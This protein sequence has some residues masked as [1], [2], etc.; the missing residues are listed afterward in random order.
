[1]W[2]DE[3]YGFI[4]MNGLYLYSTLVEN[5]RSLHK[6]GYGF[7]NSAS[8]VIKGEVEPLFE[9]NLGKNTSRVNPDPVLSHVRLASATRGVK[10]VSVVN[11][12]PFEYSHI[13]LA[14]N[15]S[16]TPRSYKIWDDP[17]YKD[18]IDSDAFGTMVNG[19]IEKEGCSVLQALSTAYESW[20]G[21]FAF[22]IY[23]KDDKKFYVCRGET[24]KL[25]ITKVLESPG[26]TIGVVINTDKDAINRSINVFANQLQVL[27]GKTVFWN[28][29]VEL[30]EN[31]VYEFSDDDL[32][33]I[34]EVK[35]TK[36]VAPVAH[37]PAF[38]DSNTGWEYYSKRTEVDGPVVSKSDYGSMEESYSKIY[39]FLEYTGLS[40]S[41][42]DHLF[43][44][45][46]GIALLEATETDI[47]TFIDRIM[48]KLRTAFQKKK[49]I[50]KEWKT[51]V[52]KTSNDPFLALEQHEIQFPY[53]LEQMPKVRQARQGVDKNTKYR[54]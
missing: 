19:I 9:H 2:G 51:L 8:G 15:G 28:E 31:T 10:Q 35:E 14:H 52:N 21:K 24:A 13:I 41:E 53:F 44:T 6:D 4:N 22:L 37:Q 1:M 3:E 29:G 25:H 33:K 5:S 36:Y 40:I 54:Y 12:H 34:G 27:V 50:R 32:V 17:L 23:S 26:K 18:K 11:S 30:S 45:I 47:Y 48:P 42:L 20:Y 43:K 7:F 38:G 49:G 46:L 39:K 16:L